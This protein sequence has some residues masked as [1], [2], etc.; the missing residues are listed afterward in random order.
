MN[1]ILFGIRPK[2]GEAVLAK[3]FGDAGGI[4]RE[5]LNTVSRVVEAGSGRQRKRSLLAARPSLVTV[6][7]EVLFH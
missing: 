1:A 7:P 2:L 3:R 4:A 5:R 6:S